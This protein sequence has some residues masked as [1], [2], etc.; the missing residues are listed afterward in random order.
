VGPRAVQILPNQ[1]PPPTDWVEEDYA[2]VPDLV[3]EACGYLGISPVRDAFA[4]PAYHR[5]SAYWTR[6][7]EAFAQSWV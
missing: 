7:D 2:M 3:A 6:E 5:F 1:G 4:T